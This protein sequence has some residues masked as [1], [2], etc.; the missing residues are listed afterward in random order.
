MSDA[1][2]KEI[3]KAFSFGFTA[4]QVAN[5]CYISVAEAVQLRTKYAADIESRKVA[6]HE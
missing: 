1:E 4:E 2:I 3:I 6:Y 5:E